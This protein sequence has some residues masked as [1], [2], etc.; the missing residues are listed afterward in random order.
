VEEALCF[1]WIDSLVKRIDGERYMQK[2]TP[3][4]RK[5]TWSKPNVTR[6]EKMI[7]EGK[8][9]EKGM[10]LY[11]YAKKKG[12]L[13]DPSREQRPAMPDIPDWFTKALESNPA[14]RDQFFKLAPSHRRNYL[15]WILDAKKAETRSRR[16]GET[17]DRLN[18]GQTLGM[19]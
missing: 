1:G 6:V 14:A 11:E 19:K 8:M 17:L 5:S 7:R 13:P 12:M 16:L 4:K 15:A 10:A 3:R 9:T 2:F 18:R